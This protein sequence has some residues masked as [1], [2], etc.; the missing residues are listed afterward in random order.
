MTCGS[1]APMKRAEFG[2]V[3]AHLQKH[4]LFVVENKNMDNSMR[5]TFFIDFIYG[6]IS[7]NFIFF[8][9]N[10]QEFHESYHN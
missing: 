9:D 1:G 7:N 8:V 2:F 3:I 10:V 4:F 5:Q 6:R